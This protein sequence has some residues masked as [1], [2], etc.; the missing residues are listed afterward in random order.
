MQ[1]MKARDI[2]ERASS[3]SGAPVIPPA[4]QSGTRPPAATVADIVDSEVLAGFRVWRVWII[5]GWNDIRQRYRRSVLGP[6][7]ITLSMGVFILMLGVIY[8]HLFHMQLG[9]YLPFLS[10]GYIIWGLVSTIANESCLAFHESAQLIKQIKLPYTIYI[11]RVVWR[12]FI[13]FLHTVVIYI[14]VAAYFRVPLGLTSLLA[15]PGLFLLIVNVTWAA[16]VLAIVSTRYRDVQPIVAT[17]IQL[18]MFATPIM[19]PKSALGGAAIVADINPIYH[20]IA[21]VREPLLDTAPA[22][23]SWLVVCGF[24]VAGPA[25]AIGLLVSKSRRLV[26]WL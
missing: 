16:M 7:W 19:W 18:A 20:L 6:F 14:P 24:A 22:L 13:V 12:N 23:L 1:L 11:Q 8:S 21:V 26:F 9:T 4:A 2:A 5:L 25:L 10:A 3:P 15:L 17:V